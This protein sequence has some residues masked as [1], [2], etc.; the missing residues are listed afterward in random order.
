MIDKKSKLIKEI[1]DDDEL[2]EEDEEIL[3]TLL[4]ERISKDAISEHDSNL[5]TGQKAA[6]GLAKFA[7]SWKFII[8]FFLILVLW[9]VLNA[10]ILTKPFDVYPFIL[11]N[12]ILS[13]LAAIQAPV[14]MMSQNRQEQKDRLRAKNDYKVNLKSEIIVE[15]IHIKL[16]TIIKQQAEMMKRIYKLESNNSNNSNNNNNNKNDSSEIANNINDSSENKS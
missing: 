13:C 14:I 16:D 11:M 10:T 8:Y 5:T 3:H 15:D 1:L 7:G 2:D 12:L 9:I 6:D 4:H